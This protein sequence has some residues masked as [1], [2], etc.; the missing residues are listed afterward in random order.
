M[1]VQLKRG[2]CVSLNALAHENIMRRINERPVETTRDA[3]KRNDCV[4]LYNAI[5]VF[6]IRHG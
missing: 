5:R 4:A 3:L 6:G 1:S 2:Q